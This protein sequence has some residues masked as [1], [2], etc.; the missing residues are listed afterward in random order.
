MGRQRPR[1]RR[2]EI[3][4][5][6]VS[7]SRKSAGFSAPDGRR[8]IAANRSGQGAGR[9]Q[10][11]QG[12]ALEARQYPFKASPIRTDGRQRLP[13]PPPRPEVLPREYV[14]LRRPQPAPAQ[15]EPGP[16]VDQPAKI[17]I[18]QQ[19]EDANHRPWHPIPAS[20][21]IC[22]RAHADAEIFRARLA[23]QQA[24]VP[25]FPKL[26]GRDAKAALAPGRPTPC[27]TTNRVCS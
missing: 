20:I 15:L 26:I 16:F 25:Q 13:L 22:D 19:A 27:R 21:P 14:P 4:G 24:G 18:A 10:S 1:T 7:S 2:I 3:K 5:A 23:A 17:E 8:Q 6:A 9:G 11:G 12:H